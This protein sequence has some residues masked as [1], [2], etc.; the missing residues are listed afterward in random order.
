[1]LY[2]FL[3]TY[4]DADN[5]VAPE[6]PAISTLDPLYF[7]IVILPIA[8]KSSPGPL[9]VAFSK[10]DVECSAP[11]PNTPGTHDGNPTTFV[12]ALFPVEAKVGT[13][14]AANN[15]TAF[16]VCVSVEQRDNAVAVTED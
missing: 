3:L 14:F 11:T 7:V 15:A 5:A 13:L 12:L 9:F 6:V 8:T 10:I 16:M 1:V 4:E 2:V